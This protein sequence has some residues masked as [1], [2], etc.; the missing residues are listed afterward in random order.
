[1]MEDVLGPITLAGIVA[2]LIE[3][4]KGQSWFPFAK[5]NAFWLNTACAGFAAL[6][7][8]GAIT[9]TFSETGDFSMAG[10]IYAIRHTL[11]LVVQ[12]YVLQHF[13][14]KSAIAPPPNPVMT[15]ADIVE[16]AEGK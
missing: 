11:Y 1:M 16:R 8:A 3:W 13:F 4:L 6:V 15:K 12:Q 9:W 10:N 2:R 5:F 7:S 14:Y